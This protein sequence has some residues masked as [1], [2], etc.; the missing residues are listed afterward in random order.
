MATRISTT[1]VLVFFSTCSLAQPFT[2]LTQKVAADTAPLPAFHVDSA[3][4][5]DVVRE[6]I[7]GKLHVL[8]R[9]FDRQHSSPDQHGR[10]LGCAFITDASVN[11][12][13]L[14]QIGDHDLAQVNHPAL[15]SL[16]IVAEENQ[17]LYLKD[18]FADEFWGAVC[19]HSASSLR[20]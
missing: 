4:N 13:A 2:C 5:D 7:P 8:C 9:G 16:A 12:N 20:Y 3:L 18:R 17:V 15:Q 11:S 1:L 6:V 19:F 14:F 10:L